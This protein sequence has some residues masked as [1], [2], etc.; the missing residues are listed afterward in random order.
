MSRS[1]ASCVLQHACVSTSVHR[2][3]SVMTNAEFLSGFFVVVHKLH[4][5]T[6]L[7]Y[8]YQSHKAT[9]EAKYFISLLKHRPRPSSSA[10]TNIT[11]TCFPL[12]SAERFATMHVELK[13]VLICSV[14]DDYNLKWH[15]YVCITTYQPDTRSNPNPN[16]NPNPTIQQHA[17]VN[18]QLNIVTCPSVSR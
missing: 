7:V 17:I 3:L 11:A 9:S 13:I 5:L 15:K 14:R 10:S 6:S 12:P 18:I 8:K 16:P 1:D 2:D 4:N